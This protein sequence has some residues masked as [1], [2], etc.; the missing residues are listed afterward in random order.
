M[1]PQKGEIIE[2]VSKEKIAIPIVEVRGV[3]DIQGQGSRRNRGHK[4]GA[5]SRRGRKDIWRA[6]EGH[7]SGNTEVQIDN[8]S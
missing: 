2:T 1:D 7:V 8:K 3:M 5:Q 4:E 6:G